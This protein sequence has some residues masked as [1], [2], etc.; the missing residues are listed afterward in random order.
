[1]EAILSLVDA[2]HCKVIIVVNLYV[3]SDHSLM[4]FIVRLL[5]NRCEGMMPIMAYTWYKVR[6]PRREV[7]EPG[8]EDL[9]A[10]EGI[11]RC[12]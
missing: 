1:M 7:L 9:A 8:L 10:T 2:D 12:P 4:A 3:I 5:Y 11:H 6:R